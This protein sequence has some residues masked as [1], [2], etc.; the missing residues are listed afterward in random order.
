ME[1][2]VNRGLFST[3]AAA[4]A[5]IFLD[6]FGGNFGGAAVSLGHLKLTVEGVKPRSDDEK[7]PDETQKIGNI[8]PDE[9]AQQHAPDG[10]GVAEWRDDG[11]R[12]GTERADVEKVRGG[13]E[14]ARA[15]EIIGL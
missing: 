5:Q 3:G 7:C 2:L 4:K 12:A 15:G 11:N 14:H 13:N 1:Y 8:P 10:R 9:E 6:A